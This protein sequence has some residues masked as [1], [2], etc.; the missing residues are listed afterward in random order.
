MPLRSISKESNGFFARRRSLH[1]SLSRLAGVLVLLRLAVPMS[2]QIS[3]VSAASY[4]PGIAP[5]SIATVFGGN[6][7]TQTIVGTPGADGTYPKQLGG[8]TVTVGGAAADLFFVSPAQINFVVP[9]LAQYG[10]L[11]IVVAAGAQ[12]VATATAT[13]SPTAPA[14][15]TTDATGKGFGAILNAIDF[16]QPPFAL[17]TQ[18]LDETSTTPIVAV[19]GTGFRFAGGSP[20]SDHAG[21]VSN[22]VTAVASNAVGKT[23][24]LPV[25]YAGPAPLYEG[26]DQ[27]N[28]Q[29]T[30]DLDTTTDITLTIFADAVPSNPVYL[31][32]RRSPA[33]TIASVAPASASPGA[34]ATITGSAFLD[35]AAFQAYRRESAVLILNDGTQVPAPIINM[36]TESVDFVVP[37][38]PVDSKG[39][40]YYGSAQVCVYVDSERVCGPGP[41]AVVVPAATGQPIGSQLLAFTQNVVES[42]LRSLPPALD[43]TIVA[44]ITASAQNRL[45]NLQ[46][47]IAA[48]RAGQPQTITMQALD[49]TIVSVV[50]DVSTIQNIENILTATNSQSTSSGFSSPSLGAATSAFRKI[51][52]LIGPMSMSDTLS[53]C[54][55]PNETTMQQ[56]T[57][58]YNGLM[59]A[60]NAIS[61]GGLV[62]FILAAAGG[63]AGGL[64]AGGVGCIPGAAAATSV[65]A[66]FETILSVTDYATLGTIATLEAQP[67]FLQSLQASPSSIALGYPI[68]VNAQFQVQGTAAPKTSTVTDL[69]S[70]LAADAASSLVNRL[71]GTGACGTCSQIPSGVFNDFVQSVT[72]YVAQIIG[73]H[74]LEN[75]SEFGIQNLTICSPSSTALS[76]ATLSTY[77]V[78]VGAVP[79]SV[80]GVP[81]QSAFSVTLSASSSVNTGTVSV[82]AD[83]DNVLLLNE[84]IPTV[85]VSVL[86]NNAAPSIRTDKSSYSLTDTLTVIGTD[87]APEL[88]VAL[89]LR[90]TALTV[91]LTNVVS[92]G[93]GNFQQT[94]GFPSFTTSGSYQLVAVPADGSQQASTNLTIQA[95]PVARFTMG[96]AGQTASSGGVLNLGVQP[97]GNVRVS[98]DASG[99]SA[100]SGT[101]T[102]WS[103]QDNA[104]PL[105]C[106][107]QTCSFTFPTTTS[108]HTITLLITTSAS[109][110]ATAT[111]QVNITVQ[112][113][114]PAPFTLTAEAP[115]CDQN[116]PAPSPAVRLDWTLS[117]NASTYDVYRN[118]SLYFQ[119][120]SG[121]TFYNSANVAAGQSYT[122]FV[123]AM[124][125]VGS[126][127]SNTITVSVPSNICQ[128]ALALSSVAIGPTTVTSGG[129][130]TIAVTLSG[131]APSPTGA[132]VSLSSSNPSAFPPPP[133]LVVQPGQ[134][135]ASTSVTAGAVGTPT[136]VTLTASYGGTSMT[137]TVTV[138][139]AGTVTISGVAISPTTVASGG[140]A[141]IAVTLSGAAPSPTGAAVSLSSTNPSAFP[142]PPTLVVQSGQ[143]TASTTIT[144]G[145]VG[146]PTSVTL[147]AS[148]GGA[149]MT[150]TATVTPVGTV[151]LS[152]V[153]ISPSSVAS[154]G[155]ATITVTLSGAAPS[156]TGVAVSLSSSNPSAFLPP[157]T[158]VVQPGQTTA[159]TTI[160]AG[161]VSSATTVTVTA[162][163][164]GATANTTVTITP[165]GTS[166]ALSAISITPSSLSSGGLATLS[167][168]LNGIASA[169]GAIVD[170]QTSN[171]T[172]F[173]APAAIT[174]PA[175]ESTNGV[176]VQAGAVTSATT[177]TVTATYG[178]ATRT[179]S[180][181][182]NPSAG[183]QVLVSPTSWQPQFTV[184]DPPATIGVRI[185][186]Q[187]GAVLTGTIT[188][189]SSWLTANGHASYNWEAPETV[190]VTATPAGLAAGTYT[191]SLTVTAPA[192]SNSPVSIA[193]SMTILT[194][195]QIT[196]T[197]LPNATWGQ[198]YTYQL[199][200]TGGTNYTWS[201]QSG[202]SLP[203]NLS[204]SSSGLISGTLVQANST[205]TYSF[206]VLV[207]D[208]RARTQYAN[209]S[210]K[211]EA[212]IVVATNAPGSFQFIVGQT[213][214]QPPNGN[215][216]ISFFA[217]GGTAPYSWTAAS[218][219]PGLRI[220]GASGY[221]VGTPTQA[222]S[223]SA[224]IT[225]T[226]A[227]GR[228]GAGTFTI[229]VVITPVVIMSG[230]GQTPPT[231]PSGTVGVAYNQYLLA[232]GGSNAGYQWTVSGLPPGLSGQVNTGATC[233]SSCSF[234]IAG[235]PSQAGSYT[236][237][238]KVT[239]SL[240]DTA[241]ATIPL[242]I[243]SGTPPTI[244]TSTLNLA[245][246][247]QSYSFSFAASGG[248]PPY[249]WSFASASPDPG[250]QLNSNGTL[251]GT[252]TVPNDCPTGPG[253]W[254]G[255]Q[256]P[257]GTFT[258]SY[259]Q[260]QVT[261]SASQRTNKQFCLPAYYPTPQIAS[262]NPPSVSADGQTHTVTLNGSNFRNNDE[263]YNAGNG[264]ANFISASALSFTLSPAPPSCT[265]LNSSYVFLLSTGA[266][267]AEGT[268]QLWIVQ[269]Y[270]YISNQV[271]FTVN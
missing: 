130:A 60:E 209:L 231:L 59:T 110:T 215:N 90:G 196:T 3:V 185:N 203:P 108:N 45:S 41:F 240:N 134:T 126:T 73:E 262:L 226:D 64:V 118:G 133:T 163:Y 257:F 190:N 123:R 253:I 149:S 214:V 89:S 98:L 4:Q 71:L 24:T 10:P 236:I 19:Y 138:A 252:S 9:P 177:V 76:S 264:F 2:A 5:E 261:D 232:G 249:Q 181:T 182:V 11:N 168:T 267:W 174:I 32:L 211:V 176:S 195:L 12:T 204:L 127:D 222:G 14:I 16:T 67:I 36:T 102:S 112:S 54:A 255:S 40:Y 223:F 251:Q 179:A 135:T 197:S 260:V 187:T 139:P 270:S 228:T 42:S 162:A 81:G 199:Q 80:S 243:N 269:A 94:I 72:S 95:S 158:L 154:G 141:T 55:S 145:T 35:G 205:N 254:V 241:T 7:G 128:T 106:S 192:A 183:N 111:G 208:E 156:P 235:T 201:L 188:G 137:A 63:C 229:V 46:Q 146:T 180:V 114:A 20:V 220:D 49:G 8:I 70:G 96:A 23:W 15:F 265:N 169:G 77:A 171:S 207:T 140:S 184:G 27:I 175:G 132:V 121:L 1:R 245:T 116:P 6:L 233:T 18:S 92:S 100:S 43:P 148:Y 57:V 268:Y 107:N 213:Y 218:M 85:H 34:S 78:P 178:G 193:V 105:P 237:T 151:T 256:P 113:S 65:L 37:A 62:P 79:F 263:I 48:A 33:P 234:Q 157:P 124:N 206:T 17:T 161:S 25:L 242:V 52:N 164:G 150:A 38:Y 258:P 39:K 153:T 120:V 53:F 142:P 152:G 259:F 248:T 202:S 250:L 155:P 165:P 68:T 28:V 115:V 30:P 83:K 166:L 198:A 50:M 189:N 47:M 216:S 244:T 129:S 31:W 56:E 212:P 186:S 101:V 230:S 58:L 147:T 74:L 91:P 144:A 227:T 104:S 82:R 247:G 172:A 44:S 191:G 119:A 217:T 21:D 159:S 266:C 93:N 125:S 160:M 117:A 221:I 173:P 238:V 170:I 200:A 26:L 51:R 131:T 99:S 66:G 210:L 143:T 239:D 86:I 109:Q 122:Y 225:A 224:A 61:W 22:H 97:G 87:F 69:I 194:P 88:P 103:W 136:T 13:V 246:V 167:V 29:L 219:P 271:N 84:A 75:Q